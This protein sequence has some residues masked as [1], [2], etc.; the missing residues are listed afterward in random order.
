MSIP[1]GIR[2]NNPLNIRRSRDKWWGLSEQQTDSSFF[3]FKEMRYGLRAGMRILY[4]YIKKHKVDTL[5]RIIAR[6]A[7][8]VEN[9]TLKYIAAVEARSGYSRK[10]K[11]EV[12]NRAQIVAIIGAMVYVECGRTIDESIIQQA[13]DISFQFA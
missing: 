7:P 6:W 8:P 2:N 1:R 11:V 5:E 9:N 4:T 12:K 3:Q 10:T 13:Y